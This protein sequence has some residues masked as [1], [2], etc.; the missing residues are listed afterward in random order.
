[1]ILSDICHCDKVILFCVCLALL[2]LRSTVTEPDA[3]RE[4]DIS[5]GDRL[6]LRFGHFYSHDYVT[7]EI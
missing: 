4:G 1:M 2:P 6:V 7:G 5:F 3:R